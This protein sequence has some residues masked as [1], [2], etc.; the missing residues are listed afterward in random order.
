MS[1]QGIQQ[2]LVIALIVAVF[3]LCMFPA[4]ALGE[5]SDTKVV[6]TRT[7]TVSGVEIAGEIIKNLSKVDVGSDGATVTVDVDGTPHDIGVG[8]SEA[9]AGLG[10]GS[11]SGLAGLAMIGAGAAGLFKVAAVVA[12]L[13]G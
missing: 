8:L 11:G 6:S 9:Q 7:E 13:L 2:R 5:E 4:F 1:V 3:M 10:G 12:R